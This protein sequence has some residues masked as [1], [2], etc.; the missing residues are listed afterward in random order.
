MEGTSPENALAHVAS[1]AERV[2]AGLGPNRQ[3]VRLSADRDGRHVPIDK[4]DGVNDIVVTSRHPEEFSVGADITH[5]GTAATGDGN[6]PF[7]LAS[8]KVDNRYAAFAMPH[9]IVHVSAAIGHIELG[10]VAAG[11]KPMGALGGRNEVDLSEIIAVHDKNA[12]RFHIGDEEQLAVGRDTD[13]LRHAGGIFHA[14]LDELKISQ[15][16][17]GN[18]IDFDQTTI[19]ELA[20]EDGVAAVDGK[21]GVI[22]AGALGRRQRSLQHHRVRIAEFQT[23]QVFGDDD[24]IAPVRREVHI[25]SVGHLDDCAG[26]AGFRVDGHENSRQIALGRSDN[27]QSLQIPRRNNVLGISTDNI[28]I[29]DFEAD[30]IDHIDVSRFYVGHV[31]PRQS[32]YGHGTDLSRPR[33]AVEIRQIDDG[34]HARDGLHRC[35]SVRDDRKGESDEAQTK[36]RHPTFLAQFRHPKNVF[37]E[38]ILHRYFGLNLILRI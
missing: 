17:L 8:S 23:L 22:D 35:Y 27:P 1:V 38:S 21:V 24:R 30:R 7:D 16:F 19:G 34:R 37:H 18:H 28:I 31:D 2:A 36:E 10:A 15:H 9:A 5:V 11:I 20:G 3:T 25:I 26:L 4:I 14:R 29:H 13:V 33:F 6:V 12:V 32:T